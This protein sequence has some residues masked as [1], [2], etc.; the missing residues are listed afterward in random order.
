MT[1]NTLNTLSN[2]ITE[3]FTSINDEVFCTLVDAEV[4][5]SVA[6]GIAYIDVPSSSDLI[7]PGFAAAISELDHDDVVFARR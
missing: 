4:D 7:T 5:P 6:Y 3:T 1:N 2:L